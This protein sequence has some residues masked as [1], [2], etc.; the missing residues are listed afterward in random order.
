MTDENHDN[1]IEEDADS[2]ST[3]A[4]FGDEGFVYATEDAKD[5]IE[6]FGDVIPW[7]V[8]FR[9]AGTTAIIR[10]Q[11]RELML[12]GR[13]DANKGI[14]PEIDLGEHNGQ[15]M[16]VSRQHAQLIARDNRITIEDLGSSNGTFLNGKLLVAHQPYRVR[17]GDSIKLGRMEL[18]V[19]FVI[20]P[21]IDDDT[22]SGLG[23]Q[24]NIPRVA[25]K[26]HLLVVDDNRDVCH[27]I[28]FV[29]LRSGFTVTLA[30]TMSEAIA[31][32]DDRDIDGLIIELMLP[33]G[34]GLDVVKYI[35][36]TNRS[37]PILAMAA[38]TGGFAMGQAIDQGTDIFLAKP[39]AV[40]EL[41][42]ALGKIV[43]MMPSS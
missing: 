4:V 42:R 38:A 36:K 21:L 5:D 16:G 39:L 3:R 22:M 11:V 14:F 31:R 28:R 37:V 19:N 8:E 12:L 1:M 23:N 10:S 40:E 13:T 43:K 29:A 30:Q 15:H 35:R 41:V 25:D 26:Q 27:V 34:N 33:D 7:V 32:I 9:V 24:L 20:K 18:L 2:K 6:I 17:E